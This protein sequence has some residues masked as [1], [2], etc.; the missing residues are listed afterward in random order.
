VLVLRALKNGR[1]I[2][3]PEPF[4]GDASEIPDLAAARTLAAASA[5]PPGR[6]VVTFGATVGRAESPTV[7]GLRLTTRTRSVSLSVAHGIGRDAE[8]TA[9][10]PFGSQRTAVSLGRS[11]LPALELG[12]SGGTA[13]PTFGWSQGVALDLG[14]AVHTA[15]NASI[16]PWDHLRLGT[17]AAIAAAPST[18]VELAFD[19]E[20][21][22]SSNEWHWGAALSV[23][24]TRSL[25]REWRASAH[26]G[27]AADLEHL[28]SWQPQLGV[29]V[30]RRLGPRWEVTA[31]ASHTF[32]RGPSFSSTEGGFAVSFLLPRSIRR[33]R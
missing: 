6:T 27:V 28:G 5:L 25:S 32:P 29:G 31:Y 19:L 3:R 22:R 30:A 21:A 26:A 23:G 2:A 13:T 12:R 7:E 20:A 15:V 14:P 11:G 16:R 4:Q 17:S 1:P 10:I 24:A 8:V 18:L 33:S 9:T